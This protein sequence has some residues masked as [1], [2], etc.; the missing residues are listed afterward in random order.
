MYNRIVF[1]YVFRYLDPSNSFHFGFWSCSIVI[2][3]YSWTCYPWLWVTQ[4]WFQWPGGLTGGFNHAELQ[5]THYLHDAR[6]TW[7][8]YDADCLMDWAVDSTMQNLE[9]FIT[10]MVHN[11][12]ASLCLVEGRR[13]TAGGLYTPPPNPIELRSDSAQTVWLRLMPN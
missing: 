13:L 11:V 6:P 2:A 9:A 12:H 8:W 3:R 7:G 10:S 1:C 4:V 5:S